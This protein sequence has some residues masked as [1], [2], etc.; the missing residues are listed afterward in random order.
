MGQQTSNTSDLPIEAS[1]LDRLAERRILFF[2]GLT[3]HYQRLAPLIDRLEVL[4]ANLVCSTTQN[5]NFGCDFKGDFEVPMVRAGRRYLFLPEHFEAEVA[6]DLV[7]DYRR[8]ERAIAQAVRSA[9]EWS[10]KLAVAA[11][12]LRTMIGLEHDRLVQKLLDYVEPEL[13]LVLH[14]YNCWARPLCAQALHRGINVLSFIEGVPYE[15]TPAGTFNGR[16]SSKICIWGQAHYRTM[17]DDGTDPAKLA[18]TGPMHLDVARSKYISRADELRA[19]LGLPADKKVLLLVMPRL[20]FLPSAKDIIGALSNFIKHRPDTFLAIKWHP[21]ERIEDIERIRIDADRVK[22]FQY[23]DFLKLVACCDLAMCTGTMAG[24][25]A[26]AFDKPLVEINW[27][28]KNINLNYTRLG[29]ASEVRSQD[30]LAVID[31][32]IAKGVPADIRETVEKF[33]E[34]TFSKLD[35]KCVDRAVEQVVSLLG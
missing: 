33:V 19:E 27:A 12:R 17:V 30:D 1:Q 29:V 32:I 25:E 13:V 3:H 23:E 31:R 24:T 35:G 18:I 9:P 5:V 22:G 28:G 11:V 26:L 15:T 10:H 20:Y 14:E 34:D 21:H 6:N 16:F 8:A 7:L 4:G 2:P